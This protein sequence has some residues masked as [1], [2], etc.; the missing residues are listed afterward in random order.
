MIQ[1][2]VTYPSSKDNCSKY[3]HDQ[4]KVSFLI[5]TNKWINVAQFYEVGHDS[6]HSCKPLSQ[7]NSTFIQCTSNFDKPVRMKF[8]VCIQDVIAIDHLQFGWF[9]DEHKM[10]KHSNWIFDSVYV[11]SMSDEAF[12]LYDDFSSNVIK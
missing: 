7:N 4:M 10:G 6:P 5:K 9:E 2:G 12:L 3:S 8:H 1:L 11:Y